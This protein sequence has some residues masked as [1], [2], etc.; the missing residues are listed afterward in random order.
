MFLTKEERRRLRWHK[1]LEFTAEVAVG[2]ALAVVFAA[3]II[4]FN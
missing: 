1:F 4:A 3:M 2:M